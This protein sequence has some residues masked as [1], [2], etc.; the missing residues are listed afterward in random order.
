MNIT[1]YFLEATNFFISPMSYF[2][3]KQCISFR[4][5]FFILIAEY[6]LKYVNSY[7][8]ENSFFYF[9]NLFTVNS[10]GNLTNHKFGTGNCCWGNFSPFNFAFNC[11][12]KFIK[13]NE[14]MTPTGKTLKKVNFPP[15]AFS[16]LT[17][18]DSEYFRSN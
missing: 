12:T 1:F 10:S 17:Y 16:V 6:Y 14:F 18:Y 15:F 7:N 9:D 13:I 4:V 8:D 3:M 5:I 11:Y 2:D